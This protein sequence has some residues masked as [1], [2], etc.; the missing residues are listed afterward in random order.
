MKTLQHDIRCVCN[1]HIFKRVITKRYNI[2]ANEI[3]ISGNKRNVILC[4][5]LISS[6][7]LVSII[8]S[9]SI[10]YTITLHKCTSE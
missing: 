4:D 5:S 6:A 2:Y 3:G 1:I 8:F 10:F 7:F 9:L